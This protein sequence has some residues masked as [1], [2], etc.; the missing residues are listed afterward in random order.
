MSTEELEAAVLLL[1]AKSR[2]RIAGR[3][4][5]SLDDLAP[6]ENLR[7]WAEEA[8]RRADA[9]AAGDLT[10]RDAIEVLRDAE[11]RL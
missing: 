6:G 4:L 8:Q 10:S 5:E 1:D 9:V 11:T 2:A 3:L 7:L